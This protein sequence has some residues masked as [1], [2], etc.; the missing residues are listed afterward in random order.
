MSFDRG[1][2]SS[3]LAGIAGLGERAYQIEMLM[4]SSSGD[5]KKAYELIHSD[6]LWKI[7]NAVSK[8]W[9]YV[10]GWGLEKPSVDSEE[11]SDTPA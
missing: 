11:K 7:T 6:I 1:E 3:Y 10:S 8:L 2:L 9:F 4:D 5:V